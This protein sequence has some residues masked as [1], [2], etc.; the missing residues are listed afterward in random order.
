MVIFFFRINPF[1]V[2]TSYLIIASSWPIGH[3]ISF[4][5]QLPTN[6]SNELL[7]T[8]APNN[9]YYTHAYQLTSNLKFVHVF[10][11]PAV[12]NSPAS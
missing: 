2:L 7:K 4:C 6:D 12:A 11:E 1:S 9:S 8:D 3:V 5:A 10:V